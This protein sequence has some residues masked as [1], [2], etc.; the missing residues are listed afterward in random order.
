[1]FFRRFNV[2]ATMFSTDNELR[3]QPKVL[4]MT[5]QIIEAPPFLDNAIK[6]I[7]YDVSS[8]YFLTFPYFVATTQ[9]DK[10]LFCQQASTISTDFIE[11]YSPNILTDFYRGSRR[12]YFF[13]TKTIVGPRCLLVFLES[14]RR[15]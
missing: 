13:D 10:R 7:L 4:K 3:K 8:F 2:I 15:G 9:S 11:T 12:S 1:M 14:G 6:M 5:L